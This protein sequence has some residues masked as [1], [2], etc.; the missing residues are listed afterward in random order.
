MIYECIGGIDMLYGDIPNADV[1]IM[2][3]LFIASLS[4]KHLVSNYIS[5]ADFAV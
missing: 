2:I 1:S 5:F 3:N 4:F